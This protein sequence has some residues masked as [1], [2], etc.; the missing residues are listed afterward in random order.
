LQITAPSRLGRRSIVVIFM[1]SCTT[2][3]W[4]PANGGLDLELLFRTG[5]RTERNRRRSGRRRKTISA[6]FWA[7]NQ[8]ED[9]PLRSFIFVRWISALM[10]LTFNTDRRC[11]LLEAAVGLIG[12]SSLGL[13][14]C[15]IFV[16]VG[17]KRSIQTGTSQRLSW[18]AKAKPAPIVCGCIPEQN[19]QYE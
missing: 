13:R 19:G 17:K 15:I 7:N 6:R 16:M 1:S 18:E 4:K 11:S 12:C 14:A 9:L 10:I 8:S 5:P 3:F 2:I